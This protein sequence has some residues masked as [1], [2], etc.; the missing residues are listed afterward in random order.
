MRKRCPRRVVGVRVRPGISVA[1]LGVE[2][3]ARRGARSELYLAYVSDEQRSPAG[4]IGGQSGTVIPGRPYPQTGP[5]S[6]SLCRGVDDLDAR[7]CTSSKPSFRRRHAEV[8]GQ[9]SRRAAQ[10]VDFL[11][12]GHDLVSTGRHE[13]RHIMCC[14]YVSGECCWGRHIMYFRQAVDE[15]RLD[16]R[17]RP[18]EVGPRA[19][20]VK[21]ERTNQ[22][23]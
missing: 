4:C 5:F 9:H 17:V 20:V 18:D 15:S 7:R 12:P 1:P 6:G 8:L 16:H 14:V 13:G 19:L 3:P 23:T 2:A 10:P 21:H 22:A 11:K